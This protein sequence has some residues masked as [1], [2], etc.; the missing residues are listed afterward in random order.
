[1]LPLQR[2][3][4]WSS[5]P[6][7]N[8]RNIPH[9]PQRHTRNVPIRA[10]PTT[11][12]HTTATEPV[13]FL[14]FV[15]VSRSASMP[16]KDGTPLPWS[17]GRARLLCVSSTHVRVSCVWEW[18]AGGKKKPLKAPKKEEGFEDEV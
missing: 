13:R 5:Y 15:L 11:V 10:L 1:M 8:I 4:C 16:G 3:L 14:I 17:L 6:C 18:M 7:N 2:P 12:Q 9:P